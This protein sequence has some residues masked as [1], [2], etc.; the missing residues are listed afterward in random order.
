MSVRE[1]GRAAEHLD[2]HGY[3]E[4]L[5]EVSDFVVRRLDAHVVFVPMQRG[6]IRHSHASRP[7]GHY[8]SWRRA[9]TVVQAR[10]ASCRLN[11]VSGSLSS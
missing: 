1:P 6:D 3:H 8:G 10:V 5:A 9:C 7:A 4:L 11:R 2:V